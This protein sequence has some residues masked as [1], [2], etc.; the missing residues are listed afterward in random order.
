MRITIV[1]GAFLP[2]PPALGGAVEKVWTAL[3]RWL[4]ARGH[5]VT[6][7]GR[8]FPGWPDQEVIEGVQYRRVPGAETPRLLWQLKW[9]DLRYTWRVLPHLP[10]ADVIVSHTFWLPI[11][12]RDPEAGAMYVHVARYPRGQLSL[13]RRAT[14]WQTVSSPI[15]QVM[16]EQA[17]WG[18][19]RIRMIPYFLPQWPS[20]TRSQ[21]PGVGK[22]P[23]K[24]VYTGRIHPEKGVHLILGAL[25]RLT[26]A[27][28]A[29]WHV[30]IVGP[31][32]TREGG[33]GTQYVDRLRAAAAILHLAVDFEP[34]RYD[35]EALND[36]YREAD[37][38]VYPSLAEKGETFGVAP[39]EAM[40]CGCPVL[41][42]N[43]ACFQDFVEPGRHGLIFDHRGEEPER[44][45]AERLREVAAARNQLAVWGAA[46]ERRAA[47]FTLD[48]I[49]PRYEEDFAAA[50]TTHRTG[51]HC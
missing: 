12:V 35:P 6:H 25:A 32:R 14:R 26:P 31:A 48:R 10:P 11:L 51:F 3:G 40:A 29:M 46:S 24:L 27:E 34:P 50:M 9:R 22:G 42:S 37:L 44:A 5:A 2:V 16:A 15:A 49:A 17:P 28:Q 47:D 45:L 21:P 1:Q 23:L 18:R 36:C 20:R 39:L 43:L 8:Q 13:Y 30:R 7:V 41:I 19:D 33:G 4:A 38:F